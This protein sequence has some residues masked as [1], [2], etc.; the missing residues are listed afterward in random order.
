M[1]KTSGDKSVRRATIKKKTVTFRSVVQNVGE[2]GM[3]Q[4][5]QFR[6]AVERRNDIPLAKG[7]E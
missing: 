7:G 3:G 5:A 4:V 1:R 6:K 2:R